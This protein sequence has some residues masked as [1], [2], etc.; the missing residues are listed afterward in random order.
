MDADWKLIVFMHN[1]LS[2][3]KNQE[4]NL[5]FKL[6]QEVIICSL[7]TNRSIEMLTFVFRY[8]SYL[9]DKN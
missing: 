6:S 5:L 3:W 2:E 7:S 1:I 4:E 9:F 8:V